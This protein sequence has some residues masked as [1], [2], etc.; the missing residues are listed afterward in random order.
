[1]VLQCGF[2]TGPLF[3][4]RPCGQCAPN[5][6]AVFYVDVPSSP[7]IADSC[8]PVHTHSK[9]G[10]YITDGYLSMFFDMLCKMPDLECQHSNY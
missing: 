2:A 4:G 10:I 9:T 7:A 3:A 8:N 5:T 6:A 1:M